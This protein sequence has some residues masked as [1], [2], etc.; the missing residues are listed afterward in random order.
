M[1]VAEE[2]LT[3]P[4]RR[5]VIPDGTGL[6]HSRP[7]LCVVGP[8]VGRNPGYVTTQGQRLSDLLGSAGYNVI[9]VS[10]RVNRYRR[11]ADIAWTLVSRAREIDVLVLEIYGGS[12][13]V[14]EDLASFLGR[15]CGHKVIL[16]LHGGALPDFTARYPRWSDRVFRRGHAM[17]SPTAFLARAVAQRGFAAQVIAN[18]LDLSEYRFRL[19]RGLAPRLFWMRTFHPVWNPE[20]AIRVLARVHRSYPEATL[21]MAGQDRG[22]QSRIRELAGRMGLNRS[23]RFAGFL[24]PAAKAR[25]GDAADI[26]INTNRIDNMPV[27]VLEAGAMGLP[28]V[29]T[30]VGGVPD[31][32]EHEHTALLTPSEDDAAMAGAVIRLLR[33]PDLAARLSTHGRRLAERSSWESVRPQWERLFQSVRSD[34]PI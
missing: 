15:R 18:T 20:M 11:L 30:N 3:A 2:K 19:R 28:V 1:R 21:V 9:S 4:I 25:E 29:S 33:E 12:S 23:V 7:R 14:V 10:S 16:W 27:A 26:F 13:F 24:D 5:A 32:L 8:M 17:V 22:W 31:L 34:N 6:V